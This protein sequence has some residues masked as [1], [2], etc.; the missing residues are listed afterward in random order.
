[1]QPLV[2]L[3]CLIDLT[4]ERTRHLYDGQLRMSD[5]ALPEPTPK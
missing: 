2:V 5:T 1:M 4:R 3:S